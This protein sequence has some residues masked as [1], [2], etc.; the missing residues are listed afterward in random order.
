MY[1]DEEVSGNQ[2][3]LVSTVGDSSR[4]RLSVLLSQTFV[5]DCWLAHLTY[6]SACGSCHCP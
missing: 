6:A 1:K 3:L 2:V 4:P 5:S